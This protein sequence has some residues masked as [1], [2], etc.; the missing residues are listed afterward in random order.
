MIDGQNTKIFYLL[1]LALKTLLE[2]MS[3]GAGN[4]ILLI[5]GLL[6][7]ALIGGALYLLTKSPGGNQ[8]NVNETNTTTNNA[9][10]G[11]E[12]LPDSLELSEKE[13]KELEGLKNKPKKRKKYIAKLEKKQKRAAARETIQEQNEENK[14]KRSKYEEK[15]HK[16]DVAREEKENKRMEA[17]KKAKEIADAEAEEE[18]DDWKDMFETT[19]EGTDKLS[20]EETGN[21]LEKFVSYIKRKKVVLLEDLATD[22]GISSTDAVNRVTALEAN[23]AITGVVD[24]R[25]KFIYVSTEEMQ[26]VA[27]FVRRKG[28]VS[29]AEL[30]RES[31]SFIDLVEREE[32][33]EEE[34]EEKKQEKLKK[35]ENRMTD[36]TIYEI[37]TTETERTEGLRKR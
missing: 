13:R 14:N 34:E 1:T 27:D 32:E 11:Y 17:A 20:S 8:Q 19:E 36:D 18:F 4:T 9:A 26:Q 12:D 7:L 23:G 30:V 2:N 37:E 22:F 35:E 6:G 25:G 3:E 21:M 24:D 10:D 29:I 28:R 16:K 15:Q 33:E 5:I 31:N